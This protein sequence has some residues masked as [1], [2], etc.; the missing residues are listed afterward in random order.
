[1]VKSY[2]RIVVK[3]L[4]GKAAMASE[5]SGSP[6]WTDS[7]DV[8]PGEVYEVAFKAD[9]PGIWMDHCHNLWHAEMGMTMHLSYEGITNHHTFSNRKENYQLE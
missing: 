8:A 2:E 6:W 1:M 3:K 7:L 5:S 4:A 9:N